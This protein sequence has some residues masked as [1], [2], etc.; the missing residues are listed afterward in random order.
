MNNI[1]PRSNSEFS[2][3]TP[4]VIDMRRPVKDWGVYKVESGLLAAYP[5]ILDELAARQ[6]EQMQEYTTIMEASVA[7]AKQA[8]QNAEVVSNVVPIRPPQAS[9][10]PEIPQEP[11]YASDDPDRDAYILAARRGVQNAQ[12]AA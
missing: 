4:E 1:N 11:T 12:E 7:Q 10:T 8:Q 9:L 3:P 2:T 5:H 6:M